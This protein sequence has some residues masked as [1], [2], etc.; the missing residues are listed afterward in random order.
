MFRSMHKP[1][2]SDFRTS[3]EKCTVLNKQEE[4]YKRLGIHWHDGMVIKDVGQI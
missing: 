1:M 2:Q 3:K 4:S